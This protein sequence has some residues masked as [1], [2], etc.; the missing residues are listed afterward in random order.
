MVRKKAPV[1]EKF[2]MEIKF[3][4]IVNKQISPNSINKIPVY[5]SSDAIKKIN[6]I[7][8]PENVVFNGSELFVSFEIP[9]VENQN[10]LLIEFAGKLVNEDCQT[11]VVKNS[12]DWPVDV[13]NQACWTS[14]TTGSHCMLNISVTYQD[15]L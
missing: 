12:G 4:E 15:E 6:E 2:L 3:Y 9:E 7:T 11:F 8:I 14:E 10:N 5:L 13:L 1:P